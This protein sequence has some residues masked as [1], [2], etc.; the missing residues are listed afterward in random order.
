MDISFKNK[1]GNA[2]VFGM[3]QHWVKI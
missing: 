2:I 3:R 1:T